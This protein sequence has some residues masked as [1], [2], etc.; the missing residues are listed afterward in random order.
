MHDVMAAVYDAT[1]ASN[2]NKNNQLTA[3]PSE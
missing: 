2:I 3:H 1:S